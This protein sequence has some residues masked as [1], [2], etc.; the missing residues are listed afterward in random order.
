MEGLMHS[1][2]GTDVILLAGGQGTRLQSVVADLP[3]PM[4]DISGRP[5]ISHLL[6]H[7]AGE[8]LSHAILSVGY[9]HE[10]IKQYLCHRHA[11][12]EITYTIEEH[13][14]GTGGGILKALYA[15]RTDRAL[16]LNGDTFFAADLHQMQDFHHEKKARLTMAL[17]PMQDCSRYGTV[18]CENGYVTRFEEK[19]SGTTAGLINGGIYL[20]DRKWLI[21][22]MEALRKAETFSFENDILPFLPPQTVAG[23]P[24]DGFFIDIGIP[25]DY[26]KACR[27]L[28]E[29]PH[30][31]LE[32]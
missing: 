26:R 30:S 19:R 4:A 27:L 5:F 2:T 20:A 3:K 28:P 7:L 18:A 31:H 10:A 23:W 32:A 17:R 24:D 15:A 12:M 1:L 16:I 9:K 21:C 14:L 22:Q 29:L 25:E 13:P 8:G 11:G 6:Q